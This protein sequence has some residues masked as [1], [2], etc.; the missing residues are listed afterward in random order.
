MAQPFLA[1]A[2]IERISDGTEHYPRKI[3]EQLNGGTVLGTDLFAGALRVLMITVPDAA[4]GDVDRVL[5]VKMRVVDVQGVKT[6][7]AGAA[8]N[9]WTVK[10]GSTAITDAIDG[11]IADKVQFEAL[12]IDDAQQ[13]IA[14]GGTLRVSRA[15]SGGD[16]S[17]LVYVYMV[18][19][20]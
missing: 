4:T 11:N 12:T 9:T 14:A 13:D 3:G 5:P 18:P 10:N 7:G 2:P 17:C 15:K 1:P 8:S 19:V 20:A 16:A 6:G